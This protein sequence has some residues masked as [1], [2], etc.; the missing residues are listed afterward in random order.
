[1]Q[2]IRPIWDRFN[3]MIDNAIAV[4]LISL[5]RFRI[6]PN[7]YEPFA[8][9]SFRSTSTLSISSAR[10]FFLSIGTSFLGLPSGFQDLTSFRGATQNHLFLFA[11]FETYTFRFTTC[12][13]FL[14]ILR[15]PLQLVY[16]IYVNFTSVLRLF[17]IIQ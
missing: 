15:F 13:V 9:L 17:T 3:A 10:I 6:S 7:P 2:R 12:K 11:C 16:Y 14:N 8:W 5:S 1:V 4:S